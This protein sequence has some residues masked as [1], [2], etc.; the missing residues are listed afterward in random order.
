VE[1][2]GMTAI[3]REDKGEGSSGDSIVILY[4][5]QDFG[6]SPLL[7]SP[8]HTRNIVIPKLIHPWA[9]LWSNGYEVDELRDLPIIIMNPLI[10]V[11]ARYL[12]RD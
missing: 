1:K 6:E 4:Q 9:K 2:F 10:F 12:F 3:L 8:I 7:P 5:K 11:F